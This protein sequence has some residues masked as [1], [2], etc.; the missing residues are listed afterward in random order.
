MLL[1]KAFRALNRY[2]LSNG[3]EERDLI[4]DDYYFMLSCLHVGTL[5]NNGVDC[6][7]TYC[8]S[9]L[10]L[11]KSLETGL[12]DEDML[13]EANIEKSAKSNK[14]KATVIPTVSADRSLD[15]LDRGLGTSFAS[16]D[17]IKLFFDDFAELVFEHAITPPVMFDVKIK[18]PTDDSI[19]AALLVL[20]P[21]YREVLMRLQYNIGHT[22]C[23]DLFSYAM[24]HSD[25]L[26]GPG[27]AVRLVIDMIESQLFNTAAIVNNVGFEVKTKKDGTAT[28]TVKFMAEIITQTLGPYPVNMAF[29]PILQHI[30]YVEA[31]KGETHCIDAFL[32]HCTSEQGFSAH[33]VHRMGLLTMIS[34]FILGPTAATK[35]D[36]FE[37]LFCRSQ[38]PDELVWKQYSVA[39]LKRIMD[40]VCAL[41][42]YDDFVILAFAAAAQL[43]RL[44][45]AALVSLEHARKLYDVIRTDEAD[46]QELLND[47]SDPV[48][49]ETL[50]E[51]CKQVLNI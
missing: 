1:H 14:R 27:S 4:E 47:K 11:Y 43:I 6:I 32:A 48:C 17:F 44:H 45:G 3:I 46:M 22:V 10:A 26:G 20:P 23:I 18:I 40:T 21:G 24:D 2:W 19:T 49:Y 8:Q 39:M 12:F 31:Q 7:K 16:D 29:G 35:N 28:T 41:E 13:E 33:P 42:E 38:I 51:V 50:R 30:L 25:E 9:L 15:W 36:R 34:S 37:G 5:K